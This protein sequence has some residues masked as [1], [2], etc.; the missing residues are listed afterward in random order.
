MSWNVKI[1]KKLKNLNNAV[2]IEGLPGLG[3]VGKIAVDFIID[4]LKA[5]K[6]YEMS[7]KKFPHCVFVNEKNLVELPG[8]AIYYKKLKDKNIFLVAGDTQPIDEVS[9]YDFCYDLLDL[10]KKNNCKEIITIGGV[11]VNKIKKPKVYCTG[12]NIK[13]LDKYNKETFKMNNLLG[14]IVGVSGLLV[15][16]A[17]DKNISA[18]NLLA[19]TQANN[20]GV[21]GAKEVLQILDKKLKLGLNFK[22]LNKE[23]KEIENAFG[24]KMDTVYDEDGDD[25]GDIDPDDLPP[26]EPDDGDTSYIG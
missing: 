3:N 24:K 19:E 21:S 26:A 17:S 1:I 2:L 7:S 4:D 6:V 10:C 23:F 20:M 12:N 8:I 22:R 18:I 11:G 5:E 9:C 25:V 13:I 16:L 14:P 15:G